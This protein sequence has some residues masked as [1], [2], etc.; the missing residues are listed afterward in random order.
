VTAAPH[1]PHGEPSR[2]ATALL[3]LGGLLAFIGLALFAEL[4]D[5]DY[6]DVSMM[7]LDTLFLIVPGLLVMWF[8]IRIGRRTR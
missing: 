4:V 3:G 7:F 1:V 2:L 6:V 5:D 8:G